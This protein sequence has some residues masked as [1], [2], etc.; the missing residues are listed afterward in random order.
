M[1]PYPPSTISTARRFPF[2]ST[3]GFAFAPMPPPPK[4]TIVG[5]PQGLDDVSHIGVFSELA[6][7]S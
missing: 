6:M 5:G 2:L 7:V 1:Y 3:I 4:N